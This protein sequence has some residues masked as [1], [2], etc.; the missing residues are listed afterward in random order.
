VTV[1]QIVIAAEV[2]NQP[3]DFGQLGPGYWHKQQIQK[4]WAD[5]M[6][7]LVPPD[8]G[9]REGTRPGWD[10]GRV[11]ADTVSSSR[12]LRACTR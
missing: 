9:V 10:G 12:K 8:G 2:N 4:L 5:G 7:T 1:G 6:Q 3:P 11:Q